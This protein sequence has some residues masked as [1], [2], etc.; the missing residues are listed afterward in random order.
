MVPSKVSRSAQQE[1]QVVFEPDSVPLGDGSGCRVIGEASYTILR[2]HAGP[3]HEPAV[4]FLQQ[5]ARHLLQQRYICS[6]ISKSSASNG[7]TTHF[8]AGPS[9]NSDASVPKVN[10]NEHTEAAPPPSDWEFL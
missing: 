6:A 1:W 7:D 2:S 4:T 3:L 8:N 10:T 5:S 9:S